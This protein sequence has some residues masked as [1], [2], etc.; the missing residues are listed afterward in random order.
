MSSFLKSFRRAVVALGGNA[1]D[2][3]GQESERRQQE[4]AR[5]A[6]ATLIDGL[7]SECGLV[8]VHGN[9]PQVGAE[10]LRSELSAGELPI[11]SLANH[12]AQTQGSM[13]FQL[14]LALRAALQARG[15]K[16]EVIT[17]V[18]LVAVDSADQAFEERSKPIGPYYTRRRAEALEKALGWKLVEDAGRGWRRVVASPKPLELLNADLVAQLLRAGTVVIAGGGG[19]IPV[20]ER[21]GECQPIDGVIDKDRTA[22]LLGEAVGA[23]LLVSLTAVDGVYLNFG[24]DDE[25]RIEHMSTVEARDWLEEGQFAAGS[26]GP[27]VEA[28]I[29]F[30]E[31]TGGASLVTSV[32]RLTEALE[33]EAGT[34]IEPVEPRKLRM[35]R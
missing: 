21:D 5:R 25:R 16:R 20:I 24:T 31:S 27:K 7:A 35:S 32:E 4:F 13:G 19:G 17:L 8:L 28:A 6:M 15:S 14:E 30:V 3:T 33:G 2:E 9:G 12:V 26:M 34:L 29:R 1:L 23:D 18:S 11:P 10:L 22:T